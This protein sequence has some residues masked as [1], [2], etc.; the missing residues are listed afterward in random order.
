MTGQLL[1]SV[2]AHFRQLAF[3][4]PTILQLLASAAS[5]N[6]VM[7]KVRKSFMMGVELR[8]SLSMS[9]CPKEKAVK[10]R[11][12]SGEIYIDYYA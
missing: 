6:M 8:S 4:D 10:G 1:S 11:R 12:R 3:A 9:G 5:E 2:E 7:T